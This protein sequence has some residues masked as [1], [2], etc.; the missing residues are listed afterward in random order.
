ME[1]ATVNGE[2]TC[3][4][5]GLSAVCPPLAQFGLT[6]KSRRELEPTV[7]IECWRIDWSTTCLRSSIGYVPPAPDVVLTTNYSF[8]RERRT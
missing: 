5:R 1:R 4:H 3:D 2:N 6:S 8:N 7:L